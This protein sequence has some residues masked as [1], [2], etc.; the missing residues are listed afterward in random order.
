MISPQLPSERI[1]RRKTGSGTPAIGARIV[2]GRMALSRILIS[3]GNMSEAY[4]AEVPSAGG[5]AAEAGPAGDAETFAGASELT[6]ALATAAAS[7]RGFGCAPSRW[8]ISDSLEPPKKL[9]ITCARA[10]AR[11]LSAVK[12][13]R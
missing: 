9:S 11:A 8:A 2:A 7:A 6:A 3:I 4:F 5:A 1:T 13:G 12:F 10:C